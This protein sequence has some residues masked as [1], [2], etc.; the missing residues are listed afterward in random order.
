MTYLR[1]AEGGFFEDFYQ[2]WAENAESLPYDTTDSE[3]QPWN[4]GIKTSEFMTVSEDTRAKMRA[5]K[6]GKKRGPY[7]P[8]KKGLS[9]ETKEK[10]RQAKLGKKR[11]DMSEVNKLRWERF[12]NEL[13]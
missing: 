8:R 10:M 11:P 1:D 3:W 12:H 9:E 4:K 2:F 6:V 13:Q 5:A 7:K